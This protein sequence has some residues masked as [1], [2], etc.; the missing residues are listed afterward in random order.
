MTEKQYGGQTG[1]S[2]G[3]KVNK[4]SDN[5]LKQITTNK[6]SSKFSQQGRADGI[7][8]REEETKSSKFSYQDK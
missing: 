7:A 2:S 8:S 1:R 6:V 3:E 4:T 5:N